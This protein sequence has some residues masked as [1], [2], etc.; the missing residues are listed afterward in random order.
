M[1]KLE[2]EK[3]NVSRKPVRQTWNLFGGPGKLT[4]IV[5]LTLLGLWLT[6]AAEIYW[7]APLVFTP[8]LALIISSVHNRK[9]QKEN[10]VR[11]TDL[12]MLGDILGT[13]RENLREAVVRNSILHGTPVSCLRKKEKR[14]CRI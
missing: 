1:K 9:V 14:R 3:E 10:T 12:Q 13:M 4:V 2:A 11:Y 8:I 7:F 5:I 6:F